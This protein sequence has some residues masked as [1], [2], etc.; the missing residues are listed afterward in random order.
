MIVSFR[1]PPELK[2]RMDEL[3]HAGLYADFSNFCV[4]AIENQLLL[5]AE[6]ADERATETA[7]PKRRGRTLA[8]GNSVRLGRAVT[9]SRNPRATS[10]PLS[11]PSPPEPLKDES[12]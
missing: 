12:A 6:Q 2:A 5:E 7:P 9:V 10:R 1:C 8:A 11:S 4:A 3:V